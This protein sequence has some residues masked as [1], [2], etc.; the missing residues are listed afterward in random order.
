LNGPVRDRLHVLVSATDARTRDEISLP[1]LLRHYFGDQHVPINN[2]MYTSRN[3]V[4]LDEGQL[5]RTMNISLMML[6]TKTP[7]YSEKAG[8]RKRRFI[9]AWCVL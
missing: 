5:L 9:V 3:P 7:I 6:T 8:W 2:R 4:V 1:T